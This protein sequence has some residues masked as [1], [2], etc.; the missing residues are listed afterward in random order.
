MKGDI[1]VF[2]LM[3]RR[4]VVFVYRDELL[5]QSL[6]FVIILGSV[7]NTHIQLCFELVK[8]C[9]SSF[10]IFLGFEKENFLFLVV[11]FN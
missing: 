3:E 10:N 1:A 5:F 8:I 6:E 2:E 4:I 11:R 9:A 7:L